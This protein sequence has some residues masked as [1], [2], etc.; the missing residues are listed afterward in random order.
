MSLPEE[1]GE[2]GKKLFSSMAFYLDCLWKVQTA[3]RV[4]PPT[5]NSLIAKIPHRS[6]QQPAFYMTPDS[7]KLTSESNHHRWSFKKFS[8]APAWW[9]PYR[10]KHL[11]CPLPLCLAVYSSKSPWS[12]IIWDECMYR[13]C[14][15]VYA[16]TCMCTCMG[17]PDDNLGCYLYKLCP[18]PLRQD[19]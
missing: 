17:R 15:H 1:G 4:S 7:V 11:Q 19:L 3:F 2:A 10:V 6:A 14:I 9:K 12:G 5:A 13:T 8:A 18:C 16:V